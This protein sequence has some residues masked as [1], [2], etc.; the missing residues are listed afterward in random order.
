MV[1]LLMMRNHLEEMVGMKVSLPASH[2]P[3]HQL[4][5]MAQPQELLK[6]LPQPPFGLQLHPAGQE[7]LACPQVF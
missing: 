4:P 6:I 7:R 5:L 3:L 1:G 2:H